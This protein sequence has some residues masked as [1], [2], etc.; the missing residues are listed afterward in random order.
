MTDE[1]LK[2]NDPEANKAKSTNSS[3]VVM[4][5]SVQAEEVP[6]IPFNS[7]QT[8]NALQPEI[9]IHSTASTGRVSMPAPLVAQPAEYHR[10]LGEWLQ[11]WKDSIR[12]GYLTLP[13]MP[14]LL[15]NVL[16]WLQTMDTHTPLGYF[17]ISHFIAGLIAILL[18]Q[19]GANL[20][21]DYYDYL[22]GVDTS[23]ALGPGGLIQQGLI[24]PTSVLKLGM[25]LLGLG[26]LLGLI[27]ALVGGPLVL[28]FGIIG[29]LCAY[30]YSGSSR[31]LSSLALG[32]LLS[33]C[34]FGPMITIA[35]YMV[36]SRGNFS[37]LALIYGLPLGLLA[38][39]VILANNLRDTDDDEHAGKITLP[40]LIGLPWSRV[41]YI[42]LLLVAYAIIIS[43]G[44]PRGAP[45][46][47]LITLWALPGAVVAITGI[48]RTSIPAALHV[49]LKQ[50]LRLQA[51]F[52]ILLMLA[53][54]VTT[55]LPLLPF[56]PLKLLHL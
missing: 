45:H 23:N 32:E 56:V 31:S 11:I 33:F 21:N 28:V 22:R 43:I 29:L 12:P 38:A 24:R 16:A 46:L 47:V 14:F 7:L 39:A 55:L 48:L 49:V 17:H 20:V 2:N 1:D 27:V 10:G 15:G 34:I 53:L 18:L 54:I 30:F 40:V 6:T 44:V 50:T 19:I 35:A 13:L 36:Q 25:T 26:G 52:T 3:H 41:L 9:S 42:L 5:D 51:L 37:P 4:A 8:I